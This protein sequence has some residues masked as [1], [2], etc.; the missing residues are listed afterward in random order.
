M[1][2]V[3]IPTVPQHIGKFKAER[4][5]M[6]QIEHTNIVKCLSVRHC[7]SQHNE[8]VPVYAFFFDI[9]SRIFCRHCR[10]PFM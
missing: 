4:D 5:K 7:V 8:Q 2:V 9:P 3:K 1:A 10:L 6:W